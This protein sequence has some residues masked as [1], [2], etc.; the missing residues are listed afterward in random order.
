MNE[1]IE[2]LIKLLKDEERDYRRRWKY[3]GENEEDWQCMKAMQKVIGIVEQL[4]E[5]NNNGW[6]SVEDALPEEYADVLGYSQE[7]HIYICRM[8]ESKIFGKVWQQWNGGDMRFDWIIAWQPL[9]PAPYKK[10][11]LR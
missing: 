9:P 10:G 11:E 3:K 5:E 6:I 4:A 1:F 2:K 8:N 7:G